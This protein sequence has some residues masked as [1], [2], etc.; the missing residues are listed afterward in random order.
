MFTELAVK[1]TV[2]NGSTSKTCDRRENH[3]PWLRCYIWVFFSP[4]VSLYSSTSLSVCATISNACQ[5][6]SYGTFDA[7]K[8]S[9]LDVNV[10]YG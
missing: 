1:I 6:I 8:M 10:M 9:V 4:C 7:C 5:S 2:V 3:A